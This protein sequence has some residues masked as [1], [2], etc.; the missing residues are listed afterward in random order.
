MLAHS[1]RTHDPL[2]SLDFSPSAFNQIA[3]QALGR[4]KNVEWQF[5]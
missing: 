1:F 3:D 2:L 4:L 5:I